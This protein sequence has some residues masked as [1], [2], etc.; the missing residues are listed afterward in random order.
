MIGQ[1]VKKSDFY[2][3][4]KQSDFLWSINSVIIETERQQNNPEYTGG[5][6]RD[7]VSL[8]QVT[9]RESLLAAPF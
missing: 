7:G 4:P 5:H 3:F 2:M 6:Y 8:S 1:L 9:G